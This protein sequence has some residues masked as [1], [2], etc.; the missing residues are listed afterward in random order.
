MADP[1]RAKVR[2]FLGGREPS[3]TWAL[4]AENGV[5]YD[6]SGSDSDN[7][8]NQRGI[9]RGPQLSAE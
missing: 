7:L 4:N 2:K 5:N 3:Y 1:H 6:S 9:I 8:G